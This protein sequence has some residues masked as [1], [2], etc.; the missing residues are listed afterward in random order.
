MPQETIIYALRPIPEGFTVLK[1]DKDYN[2]RGTYFI[3][4][5]REGWTCTCPRTVGCKHIDLI[6]LFKRKRAF[7]KGYW[8]NFETQKWSRLQ[9]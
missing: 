3:G 4:H 8:Y 7:G 6:A 1:C 2:F 9:L 5:R